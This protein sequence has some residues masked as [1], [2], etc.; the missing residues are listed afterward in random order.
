MACRRLAG[1]DA[2]QCGHL[3]GVVSL[4]AMLEFSAREYVE[5]SHHIGVA[6]GSVC[7]KPVSND[8]YKAFNRMMSETTRLNL[9]ATKQH[10]AEMILEMMDA[11]PEKSSL[12]ADGDLRITDA[13][14]DA[15]RLC[16]HIESIYTSL[17][18]ELRAILFKAVPSEKRKYCDPEWLIKT[19][20]YSKFPELV[21]EFQRAGRCFAYGENTAC[22]F[23]LMRVSEFCLRRIADS[24]NVPFN[25]RSWHDIGDRITAEMDKK[26]QAKKEDW[27]KLEPFY[28]EILRDIQAIGRGH[29]NPSLHELEKKYDEREAAYMLTVI[30]EFGRHVAGKR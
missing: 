10:M 26:Y 19:N 29:R 12:S 17:K 13:T 28:A 9:P 20:I 7:K 25:P 2:G 5:W 16:H 23:H 30:E 4:L 18:A 3:Y 27:K 24:L 1:S 15:P 11:N 21:D 22:I 8:L 14:L 6:L